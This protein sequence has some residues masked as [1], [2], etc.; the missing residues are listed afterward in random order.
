MDD[1]EVQPFDLH[2]RGVRVLRFAGHALGERGVVQIA[3]STWD[4]PIACAMAA[5]GLDRSATGDSSLA[6]VRTN[7]G[8]SLLMPPVSIVSSTPRSEVSMFWPSV[9]EEITLGRRSR[10]DTEVGRLVRIGLDLEALLSRRPD[11]LSGGE[12]ARIICASHLLSEPRVL[13]L[14]RTFGELDAASRQGFAKLVHTWPTPLSLVLIEG[15]RS[16]VSDELWSTDVDPVLVTTILE[17]GQITAENLENR[18]RTR[19]ASCR[20]NDGR[21]MLAVNRIS[22]ERANRC[23]VR[24]FSLEVSEGQV[25][26]LLGSNGSGKTTV[27]EAIAGL[28]PAT[29]GEVVWINASGIRSPAIHHLAYSP[30]NPDRDI[31]ELTLL[32]EVLVGRGSHAERFKKEDI[33]KHLGDLGV[34]REKHEVP[35]TGDPSDRK[36]ASVLARL[37]SGRDICL[38]DEP[39]LYLANHQRAIVVR[40]MKSFLTS[41][42]AII[43]A[44]HDDE[45]CVDFEEGEGGIDGDSRQAHLGLDGATVR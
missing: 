23:V 13:I 7:A 27:L 17:R 2:R 20:L 39:T 8:V 24:D 22:V 45:L 44:T 14:D 41:G 29:Q 35:L 43:C 33:R 12:T 16:E 36:L 28:L 40:V 5:F 21:A 4:L 19:Q 1:L 6:T 42:G 25:T 10:L 30:Q 37:A 32:D 31:T 26:W 34:P 11:E 15:V 18:L 9:L 38:L 3:G